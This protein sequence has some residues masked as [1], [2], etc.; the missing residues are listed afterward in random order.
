MSLFSKIKET[1]KKPVTEAER[2]HTFR[3]ATILESTG[4]G[5]DLFPDQDQL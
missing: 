1:L 3:P 5:A 4:S 2:K